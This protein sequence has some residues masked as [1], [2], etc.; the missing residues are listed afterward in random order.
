M[1]AERTRRSTPEKTKALRFG[2]DEMNLLEYSFSS[3]GTKVD[4][5]TKSVLFTKAEWDPMTAAPIE[6]RLK[7]TF[8]GEY[9]RP[10]IEDDELYLGL[11]LLTKIA[12]CRSPLV[13]FTQYEL[14][15]AGRL[16]KRGDLYRRID[17]A[18]NRL[19]G[20]Q[21]DFKRAF[22]D[23]AAKCWVDRTFGLIDD[24]KLY[25]RNEYDHARRA[26]GGSRPRG[27]FKWGDAVFDSFV[28]GF[29]K[30][31]DLDIYH[32]LRGNIAKKMFRWFDKEW[33]HK[34][35]IRVDLHRFAEEK[36]GAK[37]GQP[38]SELLRLL[39]PGF[40]ELNSRGLIGAVKVTE[41]PKGKA[42]V[43]VVRPSNSV[44][45]EATR[46]LSD[47][48][49]RLVEAL[50]ARGVKRNGK[51][52]PAELVRTCDPQRINRVLEHFDYLKSI[53]ATK[54]PGWIVS[55]CMSEQEFT[56]PRGFTTSE[57]KSRHAQA[58]QQAVT[59]QMQVEAKRLAEI[60]TEREQS[61]SKQQFVEA[62]L[63]SLPA[64]ERL[65]L[66]SRAVAEAPSQLQ[67]TYFAAKR[68]GDGT[69]FQKCRYEL[70]FTFLNAASTTVNE[71]RKK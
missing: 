6:R 59:S 64:A 62:Y 71:E 55:A 53:A 69:F 31:L 40:A 26:N 34:Q 49:R 41:L 50:S 27:W 33:H 7:I 9:G 30:T 48:Q 63:E 36:L 23:N 24:V 32:N 43:V 28:A 17:M 45:F 35:R 65:I 21:F 20:V 37:R 61:A 4:Y 68:L 58:R 38:R 70:L 5:A 11:L 42:E 44:G 60:A 8:S 15:E 54:S 3:V 13:S 56:A 22:F 10:T 47:D 52:G 14:I 18:F 16:T 19:K 1:E 66:E 12:G 2:K 29:V 51:T 39:Q 46:D 25:N 57:E 67:K